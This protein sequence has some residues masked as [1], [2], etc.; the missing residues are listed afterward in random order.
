VALGTL[1]RYLSVVDDCSRH[2]GMVEPIPPP[3]YR[4][5][6]I[7]HGASCVKSAEVLD[8]LTSVPGAKI[9]CIGDA[10]FTLQTAEGCRLRNGGNRPATIGVYGVDFR[11]AAGGTAA[12]GETANMEDGGTCLLPGL[13]TVA[14]FK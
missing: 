10:C 3:P 8:V 6:S 1:A 4:I 11:S 9:P 7:P 13:L 2:I 12:P 14:R 5:A